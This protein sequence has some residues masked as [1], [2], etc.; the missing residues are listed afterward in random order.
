MLWELTLLGSSAHEF[1]LGSIRLRV[2][3]LELGWSEANRYWRRHVP[4]T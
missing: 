3:L 4:F 2:R 1:F